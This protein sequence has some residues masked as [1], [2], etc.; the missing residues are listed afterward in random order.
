MVR[1]LGTTVSVALLAYACGG[2]SIA[3]HGG[4]GDDG[5]SGT[6]GSSGA[7]GGTST[8]GSTTGSGGATGSGGTD[9]FAL[10]GGAS[11]S[12]GAGSAAG[13]TG[14]TGGAI[15]VTGDTTSQ[16]CTETYEDRDGDGWSTYYTSGDCGIVVTA[17]SP[18]EDCD[19]EDPDLQATVYPD[20][21]GDGAGWV[22]P[23]LCV[24]DGDVPPGYSSTSNDCDDADPT[25]SPL[26]I[27]TPGDGIDQDCDLR[28]AELCTGDTS[29]SCPCSGLIQGVPAVDDACDSFD[30]TL[31]DSAYCRLG[32]GSDT[33]VRIANLGTRAFTGWI[34]LTQLDV[35]DATGVTAR[36]ESFYGTV[37]AGTV[38]APRR[39]TAVSLSDTITMSTDQPGDCEPD[40]DVFS[41]DVPPAPQPIC[42]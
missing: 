26:L 14:G 33:F 35:N 17:G 9:T 42:R 41:S 34:T 25:R 16:P 7:T 22:S 3:N 39:L 27:D 38:T 36:S 31:L 15:T 10:T 4:S 2:Q 21:D 13:G 11:S 30:L 28:D 1:R 18:W 8:G 40:N 32:C 19:D 12:G 37:G 24:A 20:H 23:T 6:G 5:A 29:Q